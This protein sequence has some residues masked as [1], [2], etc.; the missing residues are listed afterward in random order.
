MADDCFNRIKE[1][2]NAANRGVSDRQLRRVIETMEAIHAG[3]KADP[4]LGSYQQRTQ[5]YFKKSLEDRERMAAQYAKDM[6][7]HLENLN[8][9]SQPAFANA[10]DEA[11]L[12]LL[13]QP[14]R[15][16]TGVTDSV[17]NKKDFYRGTWANLRDVGIE[18]LGLRKVYLSGA[19]DR[20]IR[21]AIFAIRKGLDTSG[22]N[23]DA[24]SIAR[25]H[26]DVQK[27]MLQ[28]QNAR[29]VRVGNLSDR[30]EMQR[31]NPD[32]FIEAGF[33]GWK[34]AIL[35]DPRI[36]LDRERTFGE[37]AGDRAKEEEILRSIYRHVVAGKIDEN[38]GTSAADLDAYSVTRDPGGNLE[39]RLGRSRAIHFMDADS[40]HFYNEA[41]G[42]GN[43][44]EN[45]DAEI[46][47]KARYLALVD[48]LGT[49]PE[50][51]F[52]RLADDL[53]N[54]LVNE[55][56]L[57]LAKKIRSG[58]GTGKSAYAKNLVWRMDEVMGVNDIPVRDV[59]ARIGK[60]VR[61]NESTAK[62]GRYGLASMTNYAQA[63]VRL[64]DATGENVISSAVKL[65][66]EYVSAIPPSARREVL[67]TMGQMADDLSHEITRRGAPTEQRIGSSLMRFI[68]TYSGAN[69]FTDAPKVAFGNQFMSHAARTVQA[70]SKM[71]VETRASFLTAGIE[72]ADLRVLRSGVQDMPDGRKMLTPGGIARIP[73]EELEVRAKELGMTAEEYRYD[74]ELRYGTYLNTQTRMVST[75]A[76]ARESGLLNMGTRSGTAMGEIWRTMMQFKAFGIQAGNLAIQTSRAKP[77]AQMLLEKGVLMSEG[78]NMT[79][80]AQALLIGTTLGYV[81]SQITRMMDNKSPNLNPTAEDLLDAMGKSGIGGLY[82]DMVLTPY[83]KFGPYANAWSAMAGPALGTAFPLAQDALTGGK[84]ATERNIV[85][86]IRQHI[87]LQNAFLFKQG[88]D[89]LQNKV[90][91]DALQPGYSNKRERAIRKSE[92]K[93]GTERIFE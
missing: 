11:L 65:M 82:T 74:M 1:Q 56:K 84:K 71:N 90:I 45:L 13:V 23:G 16:G 50:E 33:E 67:Q 49:N 78:H 7:T 18:K 52:Y 86:E 38:M 35:N 42:I 68:S 9:V 40:Q 20:E 39:N 43:L 64:K 17:E 46:S 28:D 3:S 89:Y 31:H 5:N 87:P 10:P 55:G 44:A 92:R 79:G 66:Y 48:K 36:K 14:D 69:F 72:E 59:V 81:K 58:A 62:L 41:F 37:W 47:S 4:S 30:I 26:V 80:L 34:K 51:Q 91:L 70:P 85:R 75:T 88:F 19:L 61:L 25:V 2:L 83:S 6:R 77:N 60:S 24:V 15:L 63:V 29:G 22:I 73:L 12:N 53:H 54:R 32:A 57:D 76:G 27:K 93:D 8:F 21:Q